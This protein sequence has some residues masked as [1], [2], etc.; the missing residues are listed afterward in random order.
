MKPRN[1]ETQIRALEQARDKAREKYGEKAVALG[2]EKY[3]HNVVPSPSLM[4]DY[5]LGTGGFPYG[6]AVEVFGDNGL[7]KTSAIGYGTL[8]NVQRQGNLPAIIAAEP[9]FDEAWAMQHGVDPELCLIKRPDNAEEAFEMLHDLVYGNL[10]DYILFDSIGA[11]AARSETAEGGKKKAYGISGTVTSG[12]NATMPRL[13]K[14]NIGLMLI[15]QQRQDT[16]AQANMIMYE[17][18]GGEAL[19]HHCAQRIHLKPGKNRYTV[20]MGSGDDAENVLVGRELVCTFKKNKL[21]MNTKGA[22]FDFFHIATDEYGPVGV[23]RIDDIIR[24]GKVT[25][26]MKETSKGWPEHHTFPKGKLHGPAAVAKFLSEQPEAEVII[27]EEVLAKMRAEQIEARAKADEAKAKLR[28][29][30]G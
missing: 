8:A 27:R 11:L 3:T 20:K 15:N 26:V 7:G 13:W 2:N 5:K 10:I 23:D 22:R 24:T 28:L 19:K 12:L 4:L 18:P 16:S 29:V 9:I 30:D 21:A 1:R 17:S 25:G 14:N 6:H